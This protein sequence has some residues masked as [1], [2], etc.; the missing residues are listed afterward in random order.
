MIYCQP[1]MNHPPNDVQIR[2]ASLFSSQ[3]ISGYLATSRLK[4]TRA[5]KK[6]REDSNSPCFMELFVRYYIYIQNSSC[7][8]FEGSMHVTLRSMLEV[9]GR[10][11]GVKKCT[12]STYKIFGIIWV[13]PL[14]S[15]SD[16]Q[17][18][19]MFSRESQPKPSFA[20]KKL[21]RGTTQGIIL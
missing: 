20:T 8:Q 17:D 18:C 3:L 10:L 19:F 15:N 1:R 5:T 16:H 14:P 12:I 4:T 6:Y 11:L 13:V 2:M 21:G 7:S 9:V